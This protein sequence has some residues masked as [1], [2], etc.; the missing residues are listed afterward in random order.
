MLDRDD[1]LP[2]LDL[3]RERLKAHPQP[4]TL[5]PAASLRGLLMHLATQSDWLEP[6]ILDIE[7]ANAA[8]DAWKKAMLDASPE[9]N[10]RSL[11]AWLSTLSP[12][13]DWSN[14]ALDNGPPCTPWIATSN[15]ALNYDPKDPIGRLAILW[16]ASQ[17]AAEAYWHGPAD[18]RAAAIQTLGKLSPALSSSANLR[19]SPAATAATNT[20]PIPLE[21]GPRLRER[22]ARAIEYQRI[23]ASVV[24]SNDNS[25][26]AELSKLQSQNKK[27]LWWLYR[28]ARAMQTLEPHRDTALTLYRQMATGVPGGSDAWLEARARTAQTL[29]AKG[30]HAGAN[31]L[32]DLVFATYPDSATAWRARFDSR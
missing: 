13:P 17:R 14:P 6:S 18:Q 5:L 2:M 8:R 32:R 27:S 3:W 16:H 25:V 20:G 12:Q 15:D 31:Q 11:E 19:A 1:L 21:L 28:A 4:E 10:R 9:T 7:K 24:Q 23:C 22:L 30:D 29:H 26:V